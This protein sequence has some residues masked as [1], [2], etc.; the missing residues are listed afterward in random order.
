MNLGF[1][2]VAT[3]AKVLAQRESFR[4]IGDQLLL[5]RYERQRKEPVLAISTA[6]DS[7]QKLFDPDAALNAGAIGK[8]V[9]TLRDLGWNMVARSDWIK[10]QLI[11][12]A[13]A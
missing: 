4:D 5:R 13:A 2:D 3:L 1:A 12:L 9:Q 7:L 6:I 10:R 8:P 11:N